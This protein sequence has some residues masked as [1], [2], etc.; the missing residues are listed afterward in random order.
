MRVVPVKKNRER[1]DISISSLGVIFAGMHLL[2]AVLVY[3]QQ[4][5]GSWGYV[6]FAFP[7]LPVMLVLILF[8]K[9]MLIGSVINWVAIGVFGTIWWYLLGVW[10]SRVFVKR[11]E[12]QDNG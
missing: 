10:L 9:L 12:N 4:Y 8:N 3:A 6:L 7:D 11:R 1:R 5:E 2:C